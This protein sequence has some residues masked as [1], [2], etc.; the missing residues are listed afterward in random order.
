MDKWNELAGYARIERPNSAEAVTRYVTKYLIKDGDLEVSPWLRNVTGIR[1][2]IQLIASY[3]P[4][5]TENLS[6]ATLQL[7]VAAEQQKKALD[8]HTRLFED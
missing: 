1:P 8:S 2:E 6:S 3:V 5:K 4:S 7:L